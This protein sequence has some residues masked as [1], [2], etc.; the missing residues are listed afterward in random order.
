MEVEDVEFVGGHEIQVAQHAV[1]GHEV[2]GD[3]EHQAAPAEAGASR[4]S[5]GGSLQVRPGSGA[6]RKASGRGA[7]AASGCPRRGRPA[8]RRPAAHRTARSRGGSPPGPGPCRGTG[9]SWRPRR[10]RRRSRGPAAGRWR[11]PARRAAGARPPPSPVR[12][13]PGCRGPVRRRP[14]TDRR[15]PRPGNQIHRM[16]PS[17]VGGM[18]APDPPEFRGARIANAGEKAMRG[19][20]GG[21]GAFG[22]RKSRGREERRGALPRAS[23]GPPGTGPAGWA[24]SGTGKRRTAAVRET[25]AVPRR[26]RR[27]ASREARGEITGRIPAVSPAPR[28]AYGQGAEGHGRHPAA[29]GAAGRRASCTPEH[30]PGTRCAMRHGDSAPHTSQE[31]RERGSRPQEV[32]TIS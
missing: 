25:R 12:S 7:G 16:S 3:V 31:A 17:R 10:R 18:P 8:R 19:G 6:R 14:L 22:G 11:R 4:T 27:R 1:L 28:N 21:P 20:T 24:G 30:L 32:W 23:S 15:L 13:P 26:S 2:P 9:G 29:R 5:A